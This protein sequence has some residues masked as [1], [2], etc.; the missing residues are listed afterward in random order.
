MDTLTWLTYMGVI[1]ALIIF[2]G[3]VA[4]LCTSHGLK[5]GRKQATT[6][7]LG[8]V[9]A[10]LVLMTISSLGLGAVL[11]TSETAFYALKMV[12]GA[13]LVYLGIMAWRDTASPPMASPGAAAGPKVSAKKRFRRGFT[14]GISNPKDLLFFAAL[15]P[16]FIDVSQP[17]LEQFVILALT[18][19]VIDF[20]LMSIYAGLGSSISRWFQSPRRYQRFNRATGG[21]FMAAGGTLIASNQ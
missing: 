6:T 17:Q 8:G 4:L 5:F 18:W 9:A 3:P 13:Y 14:V 2:P 7:V 21:L 20:T 19:L 15:F 16:N 11:A 10:S 12:G 1:F